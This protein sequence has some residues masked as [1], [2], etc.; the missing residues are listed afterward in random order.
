MRL[1]VKKA[2]IILLC[3]CL[4]GTLFTGC[5]YRFSIGNE[6]RILR[7][8]DAREYN[9]EKSAEDIITQ[10][11]IN[12][13]IAEVELIPSDNYYV[14][15]NYL[16]WDEEPEYTLKDGKLYFND[17][18]AMPNSY[19]INFNLENTIKVY[20]PDN[21]ELSRL[22]VENSSGNVKLSGFVA[23][24]MNVTVSYG[25]LA[26][27][28]AA[29]EEA[30]IELSSGNS[31]I[32]NF[33]TGNMEFTNSYGNAEFSNMNT[34]EARLP[35]D[36]AYDKIDISMSSGSADLEKINCSTLE[37]NNSYGNITCREIKA[38]KLDAGLSSGDLK[39]SKS[40]I[41]DI[42]A[43]NSYGDVNLSLI[44]P[45]SD[46]S[47]DLDTSYG[48]LQVGDKKYEEHLVTDNA[49]TRNI[50]ASLSSGNVRIEFYE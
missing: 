6:A 40:D 4:I 1:Y 31:T 15:I 21:A 41:T 32:D 5:R 28:Q 44:G 10:I 36:V 29:A 25:N 35:K 49:G 38:D 27:K 12:T 13:S 17:S 37:L 33:Q 43:E 7:E 22:S 24:E 48:H 47:L 50:S 26:L 20:L 8:E 19:S 18:N 45:E 34:G 9:I 3:I 14:E 11:D 39:V 46:Y 42:E 23:K 16:Y 30:K 2:I